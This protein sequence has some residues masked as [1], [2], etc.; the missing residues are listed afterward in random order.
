MSLFFV[1]CFTV[2]KVM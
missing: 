1:T 2:K